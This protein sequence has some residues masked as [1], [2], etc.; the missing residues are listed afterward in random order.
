MMALDDKLRGEIIRIYPLGI[1]KICSKFHNK[2]RYYTQNQKGPP[3]GGV[4]GK[5]RVTPIKLI[6]W[7]PLMQA[8]NVMAISP[9]VVYCISFWTKVVDQHPNLV[10]CLQSY[11]ESVYTDF[12]LTHQHCHP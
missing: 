4:R 10:F 11:A 1:L 2:P 12:E 5:V 9:A 7:E 6:F 8:Q 3:Q